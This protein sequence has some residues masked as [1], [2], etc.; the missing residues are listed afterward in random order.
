MY[1]QIP[2]SRTPPVPYGSLVVG[3]L[4]AGGNVAGGGSVVRGGA[5]R[6]HGATQPLVA[7]AERGGGG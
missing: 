1:R 4:L 7:Q 6:T 2:E 5:A 3:P